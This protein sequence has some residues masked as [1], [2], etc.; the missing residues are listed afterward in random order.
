MKK[1]LLILFIVG[2]TTVSQA[3]WTLLDDFDSYDNT[4]THTTIATGGVWTSVFDGTGNSHVVDLVDGHGQ[5]LQ[6]LGG[7]A[8]RGAERDLTGTGAAVVVD[9]VQTYFWQVK[10]SYGGDMGIGD[11]V[12]DLMMGLAPDVSNIDENNAWQD[13]SVMPFVNNAPSTPYI[14]AEA[15][16]SPWWALM[17]ADTWT[18]VW[19]VINNDAT[20]PTF[21]LYYSTGTG[22]AT[23]VAGDANWRNFAG[24]QDLNAI[25]F[26]AA[27]WAD[28]EYL[29]DNIH[30][31]TG[32]NLTIPEPMTIALLGL[33]GLLLRKRR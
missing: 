22:A 19:V 9:E 30:Y 25:G 7:T 28:T 23:L 26:M 4:D 20:D 3:S 16:T 2:F 24:N 1:L 13:F 5:A 33:G 8:W 21:D 10:V 27:G 15:P 12:Y 18:N 11:W 6:A 32:E 31:D 17:S 29:I 14:N